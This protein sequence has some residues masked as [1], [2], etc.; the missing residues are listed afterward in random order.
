M[1]NASTPKVLALAYYDGATEGFFDRMS[2]DQVYFFKVVAWDQTQD[3]RLFL[4]GQVDRGNYLELLDILARTQPAPTGSIWT[5]TWMFGDPKMEAR[6]NNLVEISRRSLDT[7]AFLALGEDLMGAVEIVRPNAK[8]LVS[9][10][11]LARES[12][13]GNLADWVARDCGTT[14]RP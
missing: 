2:D 1:V 3:R 6:A 13:P 14:N 12:T 11:A 9:A 7:P 5:P 10:I 8:G 4:L